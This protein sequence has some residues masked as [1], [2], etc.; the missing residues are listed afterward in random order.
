MVESVGTGVPP[1]PSSARLS[2]WGLGSSRAH[3][4][5]DGRGLVSLDCGV[6]AR[7]PFHQGRFS[8]SH[9]FLRPFSQRAWAI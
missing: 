9:L 8:A 1:D 4:V 7:C 5:L 6:P 3:R 2:G